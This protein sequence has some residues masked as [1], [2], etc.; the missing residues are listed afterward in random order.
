MSLKWNNKKLSYEEYYEKKHKKSQRVWIFVLVLFVA[1]VI[2]LAMGFARN[3]EREEQLRQE[4]QQY[5]TDPNAAS[6]E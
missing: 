1:T 5:Y 3:R 2:I 4:A 6:S